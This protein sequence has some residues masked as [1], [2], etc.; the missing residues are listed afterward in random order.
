MGLILFAILIFVGFRGVPLRRAATYCLITAAV[1]TLISI[2]AMEDPL[3]QV[4]DCSFTEPNVVIVFVATLVV[5]ILCIGFGLGVR[6][7]IARSKSG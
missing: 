1:L 2:A 4:T 5:A 6:R 7:L 3:C